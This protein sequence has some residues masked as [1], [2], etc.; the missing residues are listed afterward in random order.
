[1]ALTQKQYLE[2]YETIMLIRKS[3]SKMAELFK[4]GEFEGHMLPCL[5]QEAIPAALSKVY[6]DEDFLITAHRGGGHYIARGCN[7]NAMWA[8]LYGRETGSM[9]G[10]GGQLHLMDFDHKA[11][12]GNAIVG[13]HWGLAA[14]AGYAARHM[15]RM[16]VV[17]GGEGS[18][19]RGTFHE[20]LNMAAVQKLPILYVVEYNDKQ[21]WNHCFETTAG[22]RIANRAKAYDIPSVTVDGNDVN[23][24]YEAALELAKG[25]RAG[26]GPALLECITF[27]FTDSVSN[28]RAVAEEAEYAR[29]PDVEPLARLKTK[30]M[31]NGI[32]TDALDEQIGKRTDEKLA[33]A[34]EFARNSPKPA[35]T[36]GIDQVYSMPV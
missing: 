11:L 19:N 16:V 8:E 1:M 30:L 24:V 29:R 18:T 28:L 6:T 12:T 9:R 22:T 21:M 26:Q 36:D 27:R 14:G 20:S 35:V 7:F 34:I 5:G 2:C 4:K 32:L 33:A 31:A 3:E 23:E 10:R 17:V 25:V 13:T 15:N